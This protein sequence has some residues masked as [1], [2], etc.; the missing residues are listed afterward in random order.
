MTMT[1]WW[2]VRHAPVIGQDGRIYGNRDV[3]CD[4]SD[5]AVF[6]GLA[7]Q[8][9]EDAAWVVT[10]LS[11]TRQTA[12]AIADHYRAAPAFEVEPH[13]AEQDFGAWQGMT[14]AELDAQR[15]GS[16]HRFWLAPAE[17]TPPGGESFAAVYARVAAAVGRLNERFSGGDI[18]C[19]SHGGPIR[20]A[21]GHALGLT[22]EAALA[23]A[24]DNCALTRLD[25]FAGNDGGSG[26][27]RVALV[28]GRPHM[29]QM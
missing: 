19:V 27:W 24:V 12:A 7:H 26:S 1:R 20:A 16:W 17:E 25:H 23:F 22:P 15:E 13:L 14:Y 21:L 6:R 18:I 2:W 3:A 4:C 8:L 10:P 11:R 29:P 28:N 5:T 9:P